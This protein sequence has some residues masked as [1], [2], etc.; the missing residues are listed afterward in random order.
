MPIDLGQFARPRTVSIFATDPATL[1]K[2]VTF[3]LTDTPVPVPQRVRLD[4]TRSIDVSSRVTCSR[5]PVEPIIVDNIRTDPQSVTV[6]G[7]LSATPLGPIG[8]RLGGFGQILRRDLRELN[9]LRAIQ[10]IGEPVCVVSGPRVWPSMAMSIN[11]KHDGSNKVE[12][13]L[14]FDEVTIISPIQIS[15]V[16]DLEQVLSGAQSSVN[17]GPQAATAVPAPAGVAG[18]L[19]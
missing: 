19:G 5:S 2:I 6:T 1:G 7:Q 10:A 15:G 16:I 13:V 12:L 8:S 18:G 3:I 4:L 9:K 17:A 14:Q 11:E